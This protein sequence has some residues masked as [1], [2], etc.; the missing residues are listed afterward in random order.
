MILKHIATQGTLEDLWI[1]IGLGLTRTELVDACL[2]IRCDRLSRSA[3]GGNDW[4][5]EKCDIVSLPRLET[6]AR[7][8]DQCCTIVAG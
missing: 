7:D 6:F 4:Y 2:W 5:F 1:D 8:E 3:R